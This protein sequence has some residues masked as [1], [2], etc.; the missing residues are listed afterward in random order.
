M[1]GG[2]E[3]TDFVK[4][5]VGNGLLP[6]GSS[7][8]LRRLPYEIDDLKTLSVVAVERATGKPVDRS[9]MRGDG[10]WIDYSG[11][12]GHIRY[13]LVLGGGQAHLQARH[14]QATGSW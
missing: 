6:E 4:A 12:P 9:K 3:N 11:P 10:A 14:L 7:G 5:R 8:A 13:V 2:N 1:F